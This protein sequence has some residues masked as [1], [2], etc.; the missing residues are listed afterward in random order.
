MPNLGALRRTV[1]ACIYNIQKCGQTSEQT[2]G[3]KIVISCFDAARAFVP[4]VYSYCQT[5]YTYYYQ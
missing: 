4:N 2:K 1:R 5:Q 3:R